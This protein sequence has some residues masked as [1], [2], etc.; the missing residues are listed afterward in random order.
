M[1]H[2]SRI[3]VAV[4]LSMLPL[5]ALADEYF[6]VTPSGAAEALFPDTA[7]K[8]VGVLTSKCIDVRW[9]VISSSSME[10]VCEAP[11]NFGQTL[12]GQ[13]AMGNSY[14]TPPRRFFRFNLANLNGVSR[15]QAS[16]W[17]E[18]Q[19]AFGQ[20][21]RTDFTGPEFHN[22]ILGFLATAGGQLPVGTA[23]PNHVLMGVDGG[24]SMRGKDGGFDVTEVIDEYP[25]A[26]GGIK[27]G[28]RIIKIAGKKFKS[29]NDYL[30]ATAK[31]AKT[32]SYEIEITRDGKI[33][34]LILERAFRPSISES[35]TPKTQV[36]VLPQAVTVAAPMSV[37]D[38]LAKLAKLKSD[39]I[40]NEAEFQAEKAKLLAR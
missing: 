7:D 17:M 21:R 33:S 22:S 38:E 5:P 1:T 12:L 39:G 13:L 10:V 9:T 19:M 15:V 18:L 3:F 31:A 2:F 26:K 36:E 24:L 29:D 8:T 35:V 28:D 32:S 6:A 40:L 27:V 23:F 20:T 16:G 30:D 14:S 4:A 34:K 11:M 25:A 37:A